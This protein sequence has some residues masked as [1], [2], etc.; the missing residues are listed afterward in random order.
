MRW[1][2]SHD[3][4]LEIW[5][6]AE[7]PFFFSCFILPT[8]HTNLPSSFHKTLTSRQSLFT[9]TNGQCLAN[10]SYFFCL[11]G[12]TTTTTTTTNTTISTTTTTSSSSISY[13]IPLFLIFQSKS[14]NYLPTCYLSSS[15]VHLQTYSIC[16][17]F[18]MERVTLKRIFSEYVYF[19][20]SGLRSQNSDSMLIGLFKVRIPVEGDIPHS[21]RSSL[22]STQS[23][24]QQVPCHARRWSGQ[25]VVLTNSPPPSS[26]EVKERLELYLYSPSVPSWPLLR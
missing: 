11:P 15:T 21:S 24:T 13:C 3:A 12:T 22:G 1:K 9:R 14:N 20:R 23:S 17:G 8:I 7:T 10:F 4:V 26:A 19:K 25:G 6:P 18:V 5:N 16:M 2:F